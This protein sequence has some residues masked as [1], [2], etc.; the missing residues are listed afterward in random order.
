MDNLIS[1]MQSR[2]TFKILEGMV[3]DVFSGMI[4][5]KRKGQSRVAEVVDAMGQAE[6]YECVM[7]RGRK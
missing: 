1:I 2:W 3:N 7:S 6:A 4:E 5:N